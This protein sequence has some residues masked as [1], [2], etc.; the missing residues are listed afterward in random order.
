[1]MVHTVKHLPVFTKSILSLFP[2]VS[3]LRK[4]STESPVNAGHSH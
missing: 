3:I 1:M 4:E 2:K